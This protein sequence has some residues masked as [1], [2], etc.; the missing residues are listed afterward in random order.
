MRRTT[1][2]NT[3]ALRRQVADYVLHYERAWTAAGAARE[4]AGV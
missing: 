1:E 3:M 4:L 2:P